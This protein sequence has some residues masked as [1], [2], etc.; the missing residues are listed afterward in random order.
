[1]K[2]NVLSPR[3]V[4]PNPGMTRRHDVRFGQVDLTADF[5]HDLTQ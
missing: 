2:R 1:M 3:Q 4:C 5:Q